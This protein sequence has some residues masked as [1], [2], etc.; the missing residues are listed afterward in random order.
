[1]IA[2]TGADR[3]A[4]W[5]PCFSWTLS[6]SALLEPDFEVEDAKES[7]PHLSCMCVVHALRGD[8]VAACGFKSFQV[9]HGR[10]VQV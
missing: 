1:M 9:Q 8:M 3:R 6:R 7:G 10:H 4:A 5:L 2:G